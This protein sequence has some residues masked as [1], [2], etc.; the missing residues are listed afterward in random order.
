MLDY[1]DVSGCYILKPWS[2][3]VWQHIQ[4]ELEASEFSVKVLAR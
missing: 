4:S 3:T 1:Y 2:Y